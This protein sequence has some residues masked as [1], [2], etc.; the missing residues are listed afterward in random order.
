MYKTQYYG[1][2]LWYKMQVIC[3]EWRY[4]PFKFQTALQFTFEHLFYFIKVELF[5]IT[6]FIKHKCSIFWR[7]MSFWAICLDDQDATSSTEYSEPNVLW[8]LLRDIAKQKY[9]H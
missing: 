3:N 9:F 4:G 7:W 8:F 5:D 2:Q 6:S 1:L